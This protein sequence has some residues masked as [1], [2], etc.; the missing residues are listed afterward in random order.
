MLHAPGELG[1]TYAGSPVACAA[2]LAVIDIIEEE[3][4]LSKSEVLGQKIESKLN[5]LAE[6]HSYVGEIRRLGSMVAVEIV[7]NRRDKQPNKDKTNEIVQYANANGLLLLSAGLKGNVIRFLAPLVITDEELS[8]GL[9][10]LE[11]AFK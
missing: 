4:L 6:K 1:G 5:E 7:N 2:A 8:K 3:N 11:T 9:S 10:I